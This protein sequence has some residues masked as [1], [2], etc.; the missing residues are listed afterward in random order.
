MAAVYDAI[1][2]GAGPAGGSAAYF[3]SRAGMRVVVLERARL[4]RYKP[5][6]GAV[7]LRQLER[8]SLPLD[9]LIESRIVAA[10]YR[11]G[12][13]EVRVRLEPDSVVTVMRDRLDSLLLAQGQA[14]VRD[15]VAVAG[16]EESDTEVLVTTARGERLAGRY[17]VGADGA[18][19]TVAR[20]AGLRASRALC[21]AIQAEVAPP[22]EVMDDFAGTLAFVF[23]EVP[24]GYLWV[25]P[26]SDHL[27]V[28]I[29]VVRHSARG[30]RQV[31]AGAM[32]HLG[33]PLEGV[34]LSGHSLPL[35]AG[36]EPLST[37]R[38]LLAGDSAGLVDPITGEGIRF[39]IESGKMAAETILGGQTRG[40]SRRIHQGIGRSLNIGRHLARIF[41][42]FPRACFALGVRNPFAS[43][44]FVGL[45][46][47]RGAYAWL[48]AQILGTLPL[49]LAAEAA[50]AL[51]G[52]FGEESGRVAHRILRPGTTALD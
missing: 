29:G 16:I 34:A 49:H 13:R 23:G 38:V 17:L 22:A 12:E 6:G 18:N 28:G 24:G 26:K 20:A 14:E 9:Q 8:F 44:A 7:P 41:Y 4:P 39:A 2:V 11:L 42:R 21:P 25:F 50:I 3:L 19:S 1:I 48:I 15:G 27:S 40:Y 32:G 30:L 31:L 43:K 46:S 35:Y 45:S 52:L 47:G 37:S 5:C 51:A 36:R 33:I 10:R